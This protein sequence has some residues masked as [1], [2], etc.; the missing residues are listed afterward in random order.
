MI[1]LGNIFLTIKAR[2]GFGKKHS[3]AIKA[4]KIEGGSITDNMFIG[5]DTAVEM[6]AGKD[7]TIDRNYIKK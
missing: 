3:T 7:V 2:V 6:E 1:N 5:Y 4:G